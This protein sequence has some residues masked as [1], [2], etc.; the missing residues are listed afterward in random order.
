[1]NLTART[2]KTLRPLNERREYADD[3]VPGLALRVTPTGDKTWAV[4][5]RVNGRQRRLTL[6]PYP[7]MSLAKARKAARNAL[8]G[9][10]TGADPATEK[11]RARKGETFGELADEYLTRHAKPK[12]RSWREDDRILNAELLPRWRF[13]KVKEITRRDVRDLID[14]IADRGAPVMAN[15]VLALVRKMLNFAVQ[16]DWIE[17]NPAW[18]LPAPGE[19]RTRDRVLTEQ[20]IREVWAATEG[21]RP[22]TR[23]LMRLRLLTAQRGGELQK[24]TWADVDLNAAWWVI[25]AKHSKNRLPH[26]VPLSPGAIKELKALKKATPDDL[27]VF[28][29]RTGGRPMGDVKAI[30]RRMALRVQK[31]RAGKGVDDS[32]EFRGHDLRRTA[33]SYM[34]AG[35]IPRLSISKIL[36]HVET[37]I[38]AVYDRHSYDPEKRA[39]LEWWALKLQAILKEKAATVLPFTKGA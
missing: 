18:K 6:A 25:P 32:F 34:A 37:G 22:A 5:F 7:T 16:R 30:A 15:R 4:R 38:T 33:A 1:M 10:S 20:E 31:A 19:E 27:W 3:L 39:A 26:R 13:R 28:A 2:V 36:N 8:L 29:G 11:Q 24:M 21:E 17:L 35:G 12:K 14:A 23:A 9:A